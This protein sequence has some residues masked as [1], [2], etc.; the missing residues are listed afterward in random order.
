MGHSI[1]R[2]RGLAYEPRMAGVESLRHRHLLRCAALG[3]TRTVC[4]SRAEI[5]GK[6]NGGGSAGSLESV[7][8]AYERDGFV[9]AR[10]VLDPDLVGEMATHV[11]F[12]RRRF[13][14]IPPEHYHHHIMRNDPFWVR[15]C[16]DPR[17][18][19]LAAS[20]VPFLESGAPMALFSSHYFC[21]LPRTGMPVLWHQDGS[22]W[23]LRPMNVVTLWVAVD[24]SWRGN[25]CLKVV[26]GSHRGS[27]R[28][29]QD[30]KDADESGRRNV[31]GSAT[32]TDA[33]IDEE[34]VV[35]LE[36]EPGDVSIHHPNIVHASDANTSADRRCGLTV[37]YISPSTQCTD[38]EQPVMLLRGEPDHR[39]ANAYRSW[40]RY[41]AGYDMPFSGCDAW[42][43]RRDVQA[44]DEAYFQRTDFAQM[45]AEIEAQVLGFVDA[46]GG[47]QQ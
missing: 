40:P 37:R 16:A 2:P 23:P 14:S 47:R 7:R 18:L 29:L 15:V 34:D 42:N 36:L 43:A 13:P 1:T 35:L 39:V 20:V 11:D 9:V 28:E 8:E 32:H 46:L 45:E 27:L 3:A 22:Y 44:S 5:R 21:K 19:D 33:D 30:A 12:L 38:P 17:L 31:L 26:R 41:R 24:R 25:G 4:T 10:G 6:H